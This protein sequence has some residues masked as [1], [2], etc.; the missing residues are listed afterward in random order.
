MTKATTKDWLQL[1]HAKGLPVAAKRKLVSTLGS[2]GAVLRA[3]SATL[4]GVLGRARGPRPRSGPA[5]PDVDA[6]L[7][8]LERVGGGF[9][10]FTDPDF[11]PLLK[12]IDSTPLG[13]FVLG[14]RTLL[15]S[16]QLAVVGSRKPTP[17]GQRTTRQFAAEL[18]ACGLTI[19]SGM[20]LGIDHSAHRG[21]LD[22]SGKTIAVTAS[23]IDVV[24]PR[25]NQALYEEIVKKGLIVSEYP[26]DTPPRR[27]HFPSRNRIISGLSLGTLVVEAG[28]PSGSLITARL[29]GEQGREVFAVPGSIHT[30][31]SRGCHHLLRQG[32]KLVETCEDIFEE[33][34]QFFVPRPRPEAAST[35]TPAP[36]VSAPLS[37]EF[38]RL[39]DLIDYAPAAM[40]QLIEQSGLT[41]DKVSYILTA[42]ELRG[43][44]AATDGGYQRLPQAPA[45]APAAAPGP[46]SDGV[47][48]LNHPTDRHYPLT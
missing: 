32:A 21:C 27:E 36:A 45:P 24:Y 22:A 6:D 31:L 48:D 33:I 39:Y 37:G 20:A 47:S 38:G 16:P 23:G 34:G 35:L 9:I 25:G 26:P 46:P 1:I 11:P 12:Q 3:D 41:A 40:D 8:A 18:S 17:A 10:G 4:A 5:Y 30:P 28:L 29:A 15:S 2:P 14:D 19:T 43:L 42:L 13:L 7:A 44:I